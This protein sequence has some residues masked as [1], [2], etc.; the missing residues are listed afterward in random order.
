MEQIK[1]SIIMPVYNGE[2]FVRSAIQIVANQDYEKKELIIVDDCSTDQTYSILK[3]YEANCDWIKVL[4]TNQNAGPGIA[5]N[6]GIKHASGDYC[7]FLDSDDSLEE[8][9]LKKVS[10]RLL[11]NKCDLLA[12]NY[13][14]SNQEKKIG[15]RYDMQYL[16]LEKKEL[17]RNYLSLHMDGSVIFTVFSRKFLIN[18]DFTFRGGIHEDVDI[19]F[20]AYLKAKS[21]ECAEDIFYIKDNRT[22]SIVNSISEA[23]LNGYFGAYSEMYKQIEDKDLLDA[24]S[25]GMLNLC[26]FK[27]RDIIHSE[28]EEATRAHLY[29]LLK[30][31]VEKT[32][33]PL[34]TTV[35]Q[36]QFQMLVAHFLQIDG[37]DVETIHE[38]EN[39]MKEIMAK[40]WGCWELAH[41]LFLGPDKI[42]TC[43]KRFFVEGEQRG[44]V[45]LL[46]EQELAK[47][48]NLLQKVVEKKRALFN[49]IN[50]CE[51][52]P[53][54]GCPYLT[55]DKWTPIRTSLDIKKLSYEYHTCCNLRCSYCGEEYYGGKKPCYQVDKLTDALVESGWMNQCESVIWGG[56]EPVIDKAFEH[57]LQKVADLNSNAVQRVITN[58][59]IFS[60]T[61]KNLLDEKR[62]AITTSID[63]GSV[64]TYQK[65]RGNDYFETVFEN[66]EQYAEKSPENIIIK[67]ILLP[68]NNSIEE[69]EGFLAQI[70][71]HKLLGCDFQISI[72]FKEEKATEELGIG[73][74]VLI[75][76]L[77]ENGVKFAYLDELARER[78][79]FSEEM[80][81]K[82][83]ERKKNI[84]DWIVFEKM[85][86]E[87]ALCGNS[88]QI[89]HFLN[90]TL[91]FQNNKCDKLYAG[92]ASYNGSLVKNICL[93]D[94]ASL[95]DGNEKIVIAGA[96]GTHAI[97]QRL[98]D[99]GIAENRIIKKLVI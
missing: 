56:G 10:K 52:N 84:V 27:I 95:R 60:Q 16:S 49:A 3:E 99:C 40:R 41:S 51:A 38:K 76:M 96:Q 85:E 24:W 35:R 88:I 69:F 13:L 39:Q 87:M 45:T 55:F 78:I 42:N 19:L 6:I 64:Q 82:A 14:W 74:I 2:K 80:I 92:H 29:Q 61:V 34:H 47:D 66:L 8:M 68:E 15:N 28:H 7:I 79:V 72:N 77:M 30:T 44:D 65:V 93:Q 57:S 43:C 89:Q 48:E 4:Q 20:K 23:H 12:I 62:I 53:C 26:A 33:L 63:A 59:T 46:T 83:S 90:H 98:L 17:L 70:K 21:I 71:K 58:A 86:S 9:F 22:N 36:T 11:L 32:K 18:H 81:Q 54:E 67:Y 94:M 97:Y 31:K 5:R 50:Q 1:F 25:V 73:A 75:T 37:F 91:F